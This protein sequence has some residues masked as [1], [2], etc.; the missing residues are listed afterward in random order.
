MMFLVKRRMHLVF[1]RQ[2]LAGQDEGCDYEEQ[3]SLHFEL[4]VGG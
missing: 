2:H 3:S 4:P 1:M